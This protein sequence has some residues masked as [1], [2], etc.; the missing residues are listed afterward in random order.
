MNKQKILEEIHK[1]E[2]HLANMKEALKG[3]KY[4]KW[5]PEINETFFYLTGNLKPFSFKNYGDACSIESLENFNCF[6]T[7]EEAKNEAEKI[8]VRRML[9]DIAKRLNKGEKID[10]KDTS[11]EKYFIYLD[12]EY[13]KLG[14]ADNI[15]GKWCQYQGTVY[16]LDQNFLDVA[17]QEIGEGR[18]IKYLK[19]E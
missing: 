8:L 6:Q 12:N 2:K 5:K 11:Q 15:W 16:C 1:A 17:I 3:Y 7:E 13:N 19:S 18:L 10:W 4:G 9:E 14:Y